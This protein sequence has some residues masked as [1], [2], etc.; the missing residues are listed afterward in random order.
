VSN[1]RINCC[2]MSL[3]RCSRSLDYCG[4]CHSSCSMS[5]DRCALLLDCCPK[6]LDRGTLSPD[7]CGMSRDGCGLP[8]DSWSMSHDRWALFLNRSSFSLLVLKSFDSFPC[9]L[10]TKVAIIL[11]SCPLATWSFALSVS[12]I[13]TNPAIT[14]YPA[15]TT[16]H[17]PSAPPPLL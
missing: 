4:L 1:L 16:S 7:C 17:H 6:S 15:K 9:N 14:W 3:D 5:F 8:L 2:G 13:S 12:R 11:F 10:F